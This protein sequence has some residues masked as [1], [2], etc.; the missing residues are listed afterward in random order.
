MEI[1]LTI[2]TGTERS[3]RTIRSSATVLSAFLEAMIANGMTLGGFSV[4]HD[5]R[6][7]EASDLVRSFDSLC[8][9]PVTWVII[10]IKD[11]DTNGDGRVVGFW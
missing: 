10:E 6:E 7:L 5:S 11:K 4:L 9:G 1:R 3:L 8:V 2:E